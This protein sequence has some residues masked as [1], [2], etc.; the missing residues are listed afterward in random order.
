MT[1]R[2]CN[3]LALLFTAGVAFGDL[4]FDFDFVG[5]DFSDTTAI[6]LERRAATELAAATLGA[7]FE[8][9]A[10]LQIEISSFDDP[11]SPIL[12]LGA[13]EP[14]PV[15]GDFTG[16]K[17]QVAEVKALT[18]R[19]ENGSDPDGFVQVNFGK[20]W[21]Y[22]DV[23]SSTAFDFKSIIMHELV[24]VL[25]LAISVC[26]IDSGPCSSGEDIY[27]TTPGDPGVWF[28]YDLFLSDSTGTP[29]ID[30]EY[31]LDLTAW[32]AHKDGG[33]SPSAGLFFNGP[34][35]MAANGGNPVGLFSPSSWDETESG[36]H[37]DDENTAFSGLIML[38]ATNPGPST[39]RLSPIEAGML[40]D[41]GYTIRPLGMTLAIEQVSPFFMALTLSGLPGTYPIVQ[42]SNLG[43]P[44]WTP[45]GSGSITIPPGQPSGPPLQVFANTA[46]TLRNFFRVD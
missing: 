5:P 31:R 14:I 20:E 35:A 27:G 24:H 23:V 16:S 13:S 15:A 11:G 10:T 43:S 26:G 18:G 9:T 45:A 38:A 7:Y 39:R 17:G 2:A 44:V 28:P 30:S 4:T 32:D 46:V 6:G 1:L 3:P 41:L 29:I 25:G 40:T 19:D 34:N 8:D 33:A 12:S 36:D 21:D 37:L 42:S 22:D